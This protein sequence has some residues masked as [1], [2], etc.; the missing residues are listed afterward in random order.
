MEEVEL[1]KNR[2]FDKY[3]FDVYE[4]NISTSESCSKCALSDLCDEMAD[5]LNN[6]AYLLCEHTIKDKTFKLRFN[7]AYFKK[8]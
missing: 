3:Y 2:I 5:T 6:I 8:L 1:D 4:N 7:N